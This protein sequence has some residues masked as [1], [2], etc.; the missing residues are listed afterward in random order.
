MSCRF[1]SAMPDDRCKVGSYR[2]LDSLA[3]ARELPELSC[4]ARSGTLP[5]LGCGACVEDIRAG[6]LDLLPLHTRCLPPFLPTT[7]V[8]L[9]TQQ[10]ISFLVSIPVSEANRDHL[11]PC[12]VVSLVCNLMAELD[13]VPSGK[14]V[15]G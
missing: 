15:S 10:F 4:M 7:S 5:E 8:V 1:V 6:R 11:A 3:A 14:Q 9:R 2:Y 13:V 12:S